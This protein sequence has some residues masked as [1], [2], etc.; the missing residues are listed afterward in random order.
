[1]DTTTVIRQ[2]IEAI[3]QGNK[4]NARTLLENVIKNEPN[5]EEAWFLLAHVAQT[6]EQARTYLERVIN[7]NPNN[8]RAK[9]QLDKLY[10]TPSNKQPAPQPVKAK[11]SKTVL[12]ML[13]GGIITL[14][15]AIIFLLG[16]IWF[17]NDN[18]PNALVSSW[19]YLSVIVRC[20]GEEP[21]RYLCRELDAKLDTVPMNQFASLSEYASKYGSDGWELISFTKTGATDFNIEDVVV[22]V[23]KRPAK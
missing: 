17:K 14:M 16:G 10:A 4:S 20:H 21:N 6:P 19:E 8:E 23:F 13:L 9:Q 5:N 11:E 18:Q 2:A 22:L 1:M 12:Y 3:K 7:I 15:L